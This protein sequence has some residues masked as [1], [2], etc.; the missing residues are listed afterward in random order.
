[1][2]SDFQFSGVLFGAAYYAE[3]QRELDLDRDFSLMKEAGFSVIR[4]GESVWS[5]WEPEEGCFELEWL[6]PI[7]DKAHTYG[8]KVILGTPTYAVP[9]W[10]Q[11]RHPEIAAETVTGSRIP[12]GWRQ[13][14][15]QSAPAYR[16]YAERVTRKILARY[17]DHPAVI[18]F[19]VDNEP[20]FR[21]PHNE[22]TFQ[23]F[24]DWLKSRYSTVKRLNEEWG[25]TYWSHRLSTWGELWRPEGNSAPQY[26]LEWRRYQASLANELIEWQANLVREYA[27]DDQFVMTCLSY[28][29]P[30]VADDQLAAPLDLV[31]GNAY[32]RMQDGLDMQ[33]T[34]TADEEWWTAGVWALFE[35]GDRAWSSTNGP[36]LVVETNAQSVGGAWENF[37]PYPGQLR[38]AAFALLAR[39]G[40]MVEYWHWNTLHFGAE[41]NWGGVLPHGGRPGRIYREISELGRSIRKIGGVLENFV[42][43]AD[44]LMLYSSE[45]KWAFEYEPLLRLPEGG[46]DQDSYATIF[47]AYYRGLFECG[48]QVAISHVS[49][50]VDIPVEDLVIQYPVIV[51]PGL[52]IASD[53]LIFHLREYAEHG[54]HLVIGVRTGYADLL[55]R[56]RDVEQPALLSG[57]AGVVCSESS[58]LTDVLGVNGSAALDIETGAGAVS[59]FDV[60]EM[61][62]AEAIA[63]F[64]QNELGAEAAVTTCTYGAGQITYVA[65]L[66][67]LALARSLGR[68]LVPERTSNQWKASPDV[69][70]FT[71]TS[72][73]RH[74][75]FVSNWS[76][77]PAEVI[78]PADICDVETGTRYPA[79]APLLLEPRA[80][81]LLEVKC[82]N[83]AHMNTP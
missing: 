70:V 58:S 18:G 17:A 32:Y 82:G 72:E 5:T 20:G 76:G 64:D 13:E 2:T 8:I 52:Q 60:L 80:A 31:G 24:I 26:D 22:A 66:P 74:L 7:L 39:G 55:A 9:P 27:R 11:R 41:T 19:Q 10:L 43:Q 28:T 4:V 79:G 53:D 23:R 65:A 35:W 54:G 40:R 67:N 73:S 78:P 29:R 45:A 71:G 25:L 34:I 3:Y 33:S 21:L 47:D 1:M 36:F 12:W 61:H 16:F 68:W 14:M 63:T 62:G 42:P 46:P 59:W 56:P 57:P 75:A 6:S 38:Q 51:A 37:P 69:T 49:H 44:V 83:S 15:D 77:S 81:I 50:L 30:Q 48:V